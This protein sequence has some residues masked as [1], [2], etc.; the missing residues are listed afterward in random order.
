MDLFELSYKYA[1]DTQK[2]LADRM[3]AESLNDFVG[4]KHI[5][6]EGKILNRM[7]KADRL[8]SM[9]FYGSSGVGKTTL[10][11]IISKQTQMDFVKLSAVTSGIS[12]VKEK[13]RKA[14]DN[15]KYE[16]LKTLI[17]I[18]EIHRFNKAQQD[19]LLPYVENGIITLIGATTENPFFEINKALISR[20]YLF[21]FKPLSRD[22][23]LKLVQNALTKDEVLKSKDIKIE[24]EAFDLL[25]EY[26]NG[27]ARTLLNALELAIFSEDGDYGKI[28]LDKQI[29]ENSIQVKSQIYDRNSNRHYDT[30]SAFIKSMRG[31]DVDAALFY[32]AKMILAGED[33][34]FVLRRMIIFAAEDIGNADPN[35]L[36]IANNA[37]EAFDK[38]GMPE[39]RI[40]ISEAVIYLTCALKNN[41]SYLA[42][43]RALDFVR[44]KKDV[45]VNEKLKDNHFPKN[46][47]A[48]TEKYKYPHNYGGYVKQSY[49]PERYI[50]K[51]FYEPKPIGYETGIIDYLE[52]IKEIENA[53]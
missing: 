51:K 1:K 39:G 21:E 53:N 47:H 31:S 40:I 25:I 19:Y 17:F 24:D 8:Y 44:S 11:H 46:D 22:D 5:V 7:I 43:D 26:S 41:S 38:V 9:I 23:L 2:P 12:E 4:Q 10:A 18:D 50:D 28:T 48:A 13:I 30:I 3:R 33:M 49:L 20:M 16:G 29:I 45:E 42:I 35:A 6:G 27:D 36:V 52:K 15:L 14:Q 37:F 34:R 32:L